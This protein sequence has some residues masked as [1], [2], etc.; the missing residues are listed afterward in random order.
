M[1][2]FL[3]LKFHICNFIL[4]DL[5]KCGD[6]FSFGQ[7]DLSCSKALFGTFCADICCQA[8]CRLSTKERQKLVR[9][10]PPVEFRAIQTVLKATL[11]KN[12]IKQDN[13]QKVNRT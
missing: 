1:N 4:G 13:F 5:V 3:N 6:M 11:D 12:M 2:A 8:D 7:P 10:E 9:F